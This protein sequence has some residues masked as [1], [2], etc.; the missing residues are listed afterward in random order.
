M[1]N[2]PQVFPTLAAE[3]IAFSCMFEPIADRPGKTRKRPCNAQ[4][5]GLGEWNDRKNQMPM[6]VAIAQSHALTAAATDTT[7]QYGVGIAFDGTNNRWLIDLDNAVGPDG[8]WT[9]RTLQILAVFEGAGREISQSGRGWHIFCKAMLPPV[10]HN[11]QA[12]G[13]EIHGHRKFAALTGTAASGDPDLDCTPQVQWFLDTYFTGTSPVA[14][15]YIA[16]SWASALLEPPHPSHTPIPDDEQLIARMLSSG[17]TPEQAFCGESSKVQRLWAGDISGYPSGSE[18]DAG[19]ACM[20]AFWTGNDAGRIERLMRRSGLARHK[21]DREDILPR[22]ILFARRKTTV[23][24]NSGHYGSADTSTTTHSSQASGVLPPVANSAPLDG[25]QQQQLFAGCTYV[26]LDNKVFTPEGELL[27]E[28]QFKAVYGGYTHMMEHASAKL[29]RNAFEAFTQ[30]Q[31]WEKPMAYATCFSPKH[32]FAELIEKDG[33][34]WVN[35]F[36]PI[37]PARVQGDITPFLDHIAKLIPNERDRE[38]FLCYLTA[39]VQHQGDKFL[40]CT[41][42]QG[43][44]GNGK[45]FIMECIRYCIG[46]KYCASIEAHDLIDPFNDFQYKKILVV[47]EEIYSLEDRVGSEDKLKNKITNRFQR[48][49]TKNVVAIDREVCCNYILCTNHKDALKIASDERRYAV[50]FTAQQYAQDKDRDGLT[51]EYFKQLYNWREN[52]QGKEII[53]DYLNTYPI[54]PEFNPASCG[55]APRTSSK[56]EAVEQSYSPIEQE[57]LE[58]ILNEDIGF[59]GGWISSSYFNSLLDRVKVGGRISLYRRARILQGLGY[60]KHP[61]LADGRSVNILQPDNGKTRLYVK[62]DSVLLDLQDSRQVELEYM[63]AQR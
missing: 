58:A 27:N 5:I 56:Q 10:T 48:I 41:L 50:F 59:R 6:A 57:V 26:R 44:K 2:L 63:K 37:T 16:T 13:L 4:G 38:I 11:N 32:A 47:V 54:N 62:R 19:L 61:A 17:L 49:N 60:I 9:P 45:S 25:S 34:T 15:A 30:S 29:S 35:E 1:D 40:W 39:L 51:R 8:Q 28:A 36:K 20:L 55:D 14:T 12:E 21:Y 43:V 52:Q 22:V 46:D 53:C 18:A 42:L 7:V 33:K 31:F 23:F 3:P 24:Y